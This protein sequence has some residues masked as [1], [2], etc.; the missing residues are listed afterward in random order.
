MWT[1]HPAKI[2]ITDIGPGATKQLIEDVFSPFGTIEELHLRYTNAATHGYAV[3]K[4]TN[5]S[6]TETQENI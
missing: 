4:Y 5:E 6:D 1:P 2:V 3:L